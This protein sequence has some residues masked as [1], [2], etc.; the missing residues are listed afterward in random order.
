M[1]HPRLCA[2]KNIMDTYTS[3][4]ILP[5]CRH[6]LTH[7]PFAILGREE[8]SPRY[9]RWATFGGRKKS[10]DVDVYHSAAREFCEES[11]HSI[12]LANL[13]STSVLQVAQYLR[14]G[15]YILKIII[16]KAGRGRRCEF[17]VMARYEEGLPQRFMALRAAQLQLE[18]YRRRENGPEMV[19]WWIPGT[20]INPATGECYVI[21]DY[22]EK[23][24]VQ[25]WGFDDLQLAADN[26]GYIPYTRR[27]AC[28]S[29]FRL[30]FVPLLRTLLPILTDPEPVVAGFTGAVS[31]CTWQA[32]DTVCPQ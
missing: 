16:D 9:K 21:P 28:S 19:P 1:S 5:I 12:A 15:N 14:E 13:Q 22:F 18:R 10:T 30:D 24:S 27:G 6:P 4:G 20:L 31:V 3:A 25:F 26:N 7:K 32:D 17:V 29:Y 8:Y 2:P 11:I 23:A